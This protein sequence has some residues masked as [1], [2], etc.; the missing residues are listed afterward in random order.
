M[1]ARILK[2]MV[3]LGET[4]EIGAIVDVSTWKNPKGLVSTRY[5]EFVKDE[6]KPKAEPKV[7][8]ATEPKPKKT[9]KKE[10]TEE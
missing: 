9:V 10:K 4:L 5:I 6:A 2:R 1:K 8:A 7:E 3:S